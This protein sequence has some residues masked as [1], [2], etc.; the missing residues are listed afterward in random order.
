MK[1]YTSRSHLSYAMLMILA[2]VWIAPAVNA[3]T[4]PLPQPSAPTGNC[5]V[6]NILYGAVPAGSDR[7]RVLVFV[8]GLSGM[9]EDWWTDRGFGTND[10]YTRAYTAGYRTAF[11]NESIDLTMPTNCTATRWPGN[12]FLDNGII[13]SRQIDA[14]VEHYNVKKVDVIAH[15]KGGLDTESALLRV[16]TAA[17][18]RDVFTLGTPHQGSIVADY[19]C[20]DNAPDIF[21]A[22]RGP[23]PCSLQTSLVQQFRAYADHNILDDHIGFYTGA[24]NY[25]QASTTPPCVDFGGYLLSQSPA[26]G[27]GENDMVVSVSSNYRAGATR[28]FVKPWKHSELALGKNSFPYIHAVLLREQAEEQ[29]VFLPQIIT[30]IN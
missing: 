18:I 24:G 14:I 5:A 26:N 9:A 12:T 7:S 28:L 3:Q 27:G 4:L 6:D 30:G 22:F 10:M 23:G 8:H 17:K 13:L 19:A 29:R 11:V 2:L 21:K 16:G 20:S 15:S 1:G 25:C